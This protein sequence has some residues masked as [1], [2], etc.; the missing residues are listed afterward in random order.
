GGE[1]DGPDVLVGDGRGLALPDGPEVHE[2][3]AAVEVP[4]LGVLGHHHLD[5]LGDPRGE[6]GV[7]VVRRDQIGLEVLVHDGGGAL[8]VEGDVAG[9]H[10]VEGG[11]EGVDVRGGT[12]LEFAAD[13]LG[14][15]VV[16]GA[17]G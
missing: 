13:L 7:D 9:D 3:V 16:R 11:A 8:A 6:F 10:V 1:V 15:D 14:A 17:E 4:V 12:D 5:D 2:Q